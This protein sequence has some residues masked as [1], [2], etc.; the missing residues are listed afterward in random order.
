MKDTA[1][2]RCPH[3]FRAS[4][5]SCPGVALLDGHGAGMVLVVV[6]VMVVRWQ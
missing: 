1:H 6:V 3:F 5:C 2:Q 4:W